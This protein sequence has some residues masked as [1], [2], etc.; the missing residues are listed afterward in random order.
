MRLPRTPFSRDRA[1]VRVCLAFSC[2]AV[3]P[4]AEAEGDYLH[5]AFADGAGRPFAAGDTARPFAVDGA[6]HPF[7]A[8]DAE[9][10]SAVDDAEHLFA[11]DDSSPAAHESL[12][13][14]GLLC[15]AP[16]PG[17]PQHCDC[18]REDFLPRVLFP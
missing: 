13:R 6:V 12:L 14:V 18:C 5:L 7:A 9:R 2:L 4:W 8:G 1:I 10:P 15:C 16:R 17:F 11:A 3:V